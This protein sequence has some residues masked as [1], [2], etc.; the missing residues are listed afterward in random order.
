MSENNILTKEQLIAYNMQMLNRGEP[1]QWDFAGY[2]KHD[3]YR[4]ADLA[5]KKQLSDKQAHWIAA[6]LKKYTR[7]QLTEIA[8]VIDDT[9]EYYKA[10][11]A[12]P[13]SLDT[14]VEV[15]GKNKLR[16]AILWQFNKKFAE[17]L[18]QKKTSENCQLNWQSTQG[19]WIIRVTWENLK[20]LISDFESVGL[21]CEN[22]KSL[23]KPSR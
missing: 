21:N 22:L 3:F 20:A 14:K 23:K 4:M 5:D 9:I 2:N 12:V 7:T 17:L 6:V 8:E 1:N 18:K 10:C 15:A 19:A 16:V 13:I 11:S